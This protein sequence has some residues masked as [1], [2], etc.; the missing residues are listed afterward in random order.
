MKKTLIVAGLG[1]ALMIS[2]SY[3]IFSYKGDKT[4]AATP[5]NHE[6][7]Q[8][9]P[10]VSPAE[11]DKASKDIGEIKKEDDLYYTIITL[12]LQKLEF[13]GEKNYHI[14]GTP[15]VKRLQFNLTNL[16]YL[17][18]RAVAIK[19]SE[20]YQKTLDKWLK[21]DFSNMENDYLTIRNIKTD[22]SQ[23][24]ESPV[25]KVRTTEEEQKY[26]EHFF[27]EEGLQINKRDWKY[28]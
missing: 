17:K 11:L 4:E 26:I 14:P 16:Q 15:D 7:T 19:A 27:G 12:A 8:Q 23:P 1:L 9:V 18:N 6:A 28:L 25:L 22:T 10:K 3:S 21:G 2:G 24:G 13:R 20:L 5:A